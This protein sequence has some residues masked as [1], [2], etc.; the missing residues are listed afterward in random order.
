MLR[1][2]IKNSACFEYGMIMLITVYCA[3]S[4][5]AIYLHSYMSVSVFHCSG[6]LVL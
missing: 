4:D 2:E 3:V 1:M 5:N 6:V